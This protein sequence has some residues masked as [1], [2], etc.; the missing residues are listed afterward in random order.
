MKIFRRIIHKIPHCSDIFYYKLFLYKLYVCKLFI[1]KLLES[2]KRELH[3]ALTKHYCKI[4]EVDL[5]TDW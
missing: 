4:I 3:T 5:A 2:M 1:C